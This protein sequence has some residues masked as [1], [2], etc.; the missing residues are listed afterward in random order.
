MNTHDKTTICYGKAV[1]ALVVGLAVLSIYIMGCVSSRATW[2]PD[3]SKIALL[4]TQPRDN[5]SVL[6]IYTYDVNTDERILLDKVIGKDS[7]LSTPSWSPDGKWIAYYK[8]DPSETADLDES[9][10]T[11][12]RSENSSDEIPA[13]LVSDSNDNML[14]GKEAV[15]EKNQEVE[16]LKVQL[17]IITPDGSRQ[18]VLQVIDWADDDSDSLGDIMLSRPVWSQD[19]ETI[20]F[21]RRL[22]RAEEYEICS[23]DMTDRQVRSHVKSPYNIPIVSPDGNW[24]TSFKNGEKVVIL[25]DISSEAEMLVEIDLQGNEEL[26]GD[27]MI[28]WSPDSKHIFLQAEKNA[29]RALDVTGEYELE[30]KDSDANVILCPSFCSTDNRLYYLA[31]HETDNPNYPDGMIYLKRMNLEDGQIEA[32]FE[33]YDLPKIGDGVSFSI[34]PNGKISL[35]RCIIDDENGADKSAFVLWNGQNRTMVETDSWLIEPRYTYED[36]ILEEKITGQWLGEDGTMLDFLPMEEEIAYDVIVVET[37]GE[38]E[39]YFAHLM[40]FEDMM[41]LGLFHDE[42]VLQQEDSQGFHVVPDV[43]LRVGQI[44]PKLL[45]QKVDYEEVFEKMKNSL[46]LLMQ[47]SVSTEYAFEGVRLELAD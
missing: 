46:A 5:L 9:Q 38:E 47:Q 29:F 33:L 30:Y 8:V 23:I 18:E 4:V 14:I 2:S 27:V 6:G 39:Q 1:T 37:D 10:A 7:I 19:S 12:A 20:F 3:S 28:L 15:T 17:M 31:V 22:S 42:S 45:L 13:A 32:V 36:L 35:L 11:T 21:V 16:V 41:F 34:S 26:I 40:K 25:T 24:L 44:E 43:F